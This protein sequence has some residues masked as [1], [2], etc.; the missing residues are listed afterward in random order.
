MTDWSKTKILELLEKNDLAVARALVRIHQNQT[1]DEQ[2][3]HDTKYRN[4]KGFKPCHAK[5]ATNMVEFFKS[6]GYLTAK[7]IAYWR[8]REKNGTMRIGVYA[9]QLLREV[10]NANS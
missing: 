5:V 9:S 3:N 8:V 6:R 1:F 7:Q 4:N 2:V 10:K